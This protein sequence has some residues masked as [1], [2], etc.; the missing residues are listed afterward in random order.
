MTHLLW[1]RCPD[2]RLWVDGISRDVAEKGRAIMSAPLPSIA[3]SGFHG[4]DFS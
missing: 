1:R 3:R 2:S 4:G